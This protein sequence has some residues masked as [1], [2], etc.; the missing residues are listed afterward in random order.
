MALLFLCFFFRFVC[1]CV[2]CL[3]VSYFFFFFGGGGGGYIAD[4]RTLLI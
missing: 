2:F 3:F 4:A 1:V